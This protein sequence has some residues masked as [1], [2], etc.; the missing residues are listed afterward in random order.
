MS[1]EEILKAK[2]RQVNQAMVA[3]DTATLAKLLKPDTVLV[4]MT[5]YVQPVSEWLT[6]I[7]TGEMTYYSWHEEAIKNLKIEGT[8]ASLIG[9]S[10]VKARIWGTGPAT[11]PLQIEM[12]FEKQ[13]TDWVIVKQ[14]ASSY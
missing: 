11:W 12:F 8:K 9:Q 6:Q 4:H 10:Q 14:V 3:K 1:D 13:A 5:G 7:E 2:Y